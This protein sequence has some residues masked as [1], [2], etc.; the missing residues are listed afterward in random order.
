[1]PINSNSMDLAA[2]KGPVKRCPLC[3]ARTPSAVLDSL[4]SGKTC[5]LCL[6]HGYV[7][8]CLNCGGTGQQRGRSVWDGGRSEHTSTCT[9]CG[10]TGAYAT[11]KPAN[12]VEPVE[13]VE[14][15]ETKVVDNVAITV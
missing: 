2:H 8:S 9:P 5:K 12:W 10:G 11:R 14:P 13:L 3:S 6:G 15:T 4:T 1:M 7:S